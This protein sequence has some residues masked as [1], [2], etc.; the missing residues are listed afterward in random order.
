MPY[1]PITALPTAPARTDDPATFITLADAF[2]A[3]LAQW[4]TD[5]NAS[6]TYIDAVGV[7][8][9]LDATAA[10]A[11]EAAAEAA[12][13]SAEQAA[14]AVGWVSGTTYAIGDVVWSTADFL[15]YRR[16]TAGA[17]TT[18]PSLDPTNWAK[19]GGMLSWVATAK[20]TNFNF[21]VNQGERVDTLTTGAVTGTLPPSPVD[22][23]RVGWVDSKA[24]FVNANFT[25][26]RNGKNINGSASDFI[27]DLTGLNGEAVFHATDNNWSI[28]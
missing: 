19:L 26:G 25:L 10:A 24:N 5:V 2:I 6:G 9:D 1:T 23:D 18:D 14:G 21:T 28:I 15:S 4:E 22:G 16:K 11:S 7:Q 20:T 13:E 8:V 3:A 17:G 27:I 12:Q